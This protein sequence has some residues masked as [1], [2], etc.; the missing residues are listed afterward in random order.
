MIPSSITSLGFEPTE[1]LSTLYVTKGNQEFFA[2]LFTRNNQLYIAIKCGKDKYLMV[3]VLEKQVDALLRGQTSL[4]GILR[5]ADEIYAIPEHR[6]IQGNRLRLAI[7]LFY[8][9]TFGLIKT[10]PNAFYHWN[11]YYF[12]REMIR[13]NTYAP[14]ASYLTMG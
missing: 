10:I 12:K 2:G 11:E 6:T 14:R 4:T 9:A 5:E 8:Q 7:R 3:P 13:Q 1:C